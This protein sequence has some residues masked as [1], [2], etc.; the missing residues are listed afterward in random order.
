M[1]CRRY[2]KWLAHVHENA[3]RH[4]IRQTNNMINNLF[5]MRFNFPFNISLM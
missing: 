5:I 2:Q 4:I 3:I 1:L